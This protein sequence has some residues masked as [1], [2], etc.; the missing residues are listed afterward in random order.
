MIY[1]AFI[2]GLLV[3]G[4]AWYFQRRDYDRLYADYRHVL[5][6]FSVRTGGKV[7]FRQ[8]KET[9]PPT[10]TPFQ[11]DLPRIVTPDM[12]FAEAEDAELTAADLEHL[13][14]DTSAN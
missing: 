4:S 8:Q 10:K 14:F 2:F 9:G 7:I 1:V 5:N 6:E 3:G 11:K 12:A 13:G